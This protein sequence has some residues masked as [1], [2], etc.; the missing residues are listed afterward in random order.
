MN[1]KNAALCSIIKLC[2][3]T[4]VML[5]YGEAMA[6]ETAPGDYE[7]LPPNGNALLLYGQYAQST[8]FYASGNKVS[9]NFRFQSEIGLLRYIHAF[10]LAPN[11]VIEPQA[12]LP[13]GHLAA[14]G[15]ASFLGSNSGV[16]DL[17]LGAP[18]KVVINQARDVLSLGP[19]VYFPTGTYNQDKSLNL[20]AN[21]WQFLLQLAYIKH[22]AGNWAWDNIADVDF[23]TNN[24]QANSLGQSSSKRPRYE[25]QEYLRYNV[26]PTTTIGGGFGYVLGG[27]DSLAGQLQPDMQHELYTRVSLTQF[28]GKSWQIQG[29][30]GRDISASQG[31]K[32]DLRINLRL[33]KLF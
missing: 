2:V 3:S 9:S 5:S 24:N 4:F 21:R 31:F 12:I 14:G 28:V 33:A 25:F 6:L 7:P 23:S 20:G 1:R 29:E 18:V 27:R 15:D 19:Y 22:F 11:T 16:G 26:T 30:L 10:A 17:I 13:F 32:E 8:D